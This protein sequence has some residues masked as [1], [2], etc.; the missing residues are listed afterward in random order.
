MDSP[1]LSGGERFKP[2]KCWLEWWFSQTFPQ[3][4][5]PASSLFKIHVFSLWTGS[6][7]LSKFAL[8]FI[9]LQSRWSH[10]I[11]PAIDERLMVDRRRL[12]L[13][14]PRGRAAR[15]SAQP[16]LC[17][18]WRDQVLRLKI[19]YRFRFRWSNFAL[20]IEKSLIQSIFMKIGYRFRSRWSKLTLELEKSLKLS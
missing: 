9:L 6:G 13:R 4:E 14:Q 5:A 3:S 11:K 12:L 10:L 16:V 7:H 20:E 19:G 18:C 8:I 1:L 17:S 15:W 2:G